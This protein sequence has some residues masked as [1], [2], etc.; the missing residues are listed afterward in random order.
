MEYQLNSF[1][2]WRE[3]FKH[4]ARVAFCDI[5]V[6]TSDLW[7]F[8]LVTD[9]DC[10]SAD[11]C[12]DSA[13]ALESR[14]V[15]YLKSYGSEF[16]IID[17]QLMSMEYQ[18]NTGEWQSIYSESRECSDPHSCP[19]SQQFE[20]MMAF[21]DDWLA[22]NNGNER[23]LRRKFLRCMLDALRELD[24]EGIFGTGEQRQK[25]VLFI[26][27]TDGW[28]APF[29]FYS[30]LHR[31]NSR[32]SLAVFRSTVSPLVSTILWLLGWLTLPLSG[33]LFSLTRPE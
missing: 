19:P 22:R 17:R 4:E 2:A 24:E 18:W 11:P 6:D 9:E 5:R 14:K 32:S 23:R 31:L 8:A 33:P 21:R 27:M 20:S 29:I 16:G 12:A 26:E 1:T 28:T 13:A 30:S 7:A 10:L 3:L 25:L 15:K